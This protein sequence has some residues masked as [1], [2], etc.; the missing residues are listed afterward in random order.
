MERCI[1]KDGN[2]KSNGI[3]NQR[4]LEIS[5][6]E[7]NNALP[8]SYGSF[9]VTHH[10]WC[11]IR[12]CH[13]INLFWLNIHSK[14]SFLS[15]ISLALYI[16]QDITDFLCG[17]LVSNL[18]NSRFVYVYHKLVMLI[19]VVDAV[20]WFIFT[21]FVS[22][23][24][25]RIGPFQIY[26]LHWWGPINPEWTAVVAWEHCHWIFFLPIEYH[27]ANLFFYFSILYFVPVPGLY[28]ITGSNELK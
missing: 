21:F 18:K 11:P 25:L 17:L 27:L 15:Y 6:L 2:R 7:T 28:L 24:L 23:S 20:W 10:W 22:L 9:P 1:W 19:L 3:K 13:W 8:S 5:R 14:M 26:L 12:H 4:H 16:M